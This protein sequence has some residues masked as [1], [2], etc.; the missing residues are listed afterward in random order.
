M[1]LAT[2]MAWSHSLRVLNPWDFA[3]LNICIISSAPRAL[4]RESFMEITSNE[5]ATNGRELPDIAQEPNVYTNFTYVSCI[6]IIY[7]ISYV[8]N[9]EPFIGQ[10]LGK[11][12]WVTNNSLHLIPKNSCVSLKDKPKAKSALQPSVRCGVP[13]TKKE[14]PGR[15]LQVSQKTTTTNKVARYL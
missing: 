11:W 13:E 5:I 7:H 6:Y 3:C 12:E 1:A 8:Y 9:Y 14:E 2:P 15:Q 4:I 10:L